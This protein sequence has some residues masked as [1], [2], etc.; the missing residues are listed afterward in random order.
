[1]YDTIII[2]AGPAG[3]TAGI[4]A[5]RKE[6]KTLIISKQVGGQ[7]AWAS[8]IENYPGFK[9]IDNYDLISRMQEQVK[10]LGVEIKIDEIQKIKKTKTGN[11]I[12]HTNKEKYKTKTI[13]ITIGMSPRRLAIPGEVKFTGH[14]VSYCANCDG[15]LY[16]N[17]I[18]AVVGGGNAAL[19]AA[20][21]LSKI[22]KKVYLIHRSKEF[23]AFSNLIKI[24]N[25]I[26]NIKFILN[27]EIKEITGENKIEKIKILNNK[28]NKTSELT[29][30]G[31]FVEIGRITN[32]DLVAGFVNRDKQDQIIVNEQCQTN[33]DGIFAAGDVTQVKFKQITIACGQATIA[34]LSAYQYL[35]LKSG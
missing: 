11:F 25:K 10:D 29:I 1:M 20:D 5:S 35:Q 31:L 28:N 18:V 19:D 12:V 8:T 9:S 6:M 23:R 22:A 2:G 4:Y 33:I 24:V 27:S 16:R 26:K 34:A 30:N 7:I 21:V 14:G 3:M 17:K 32:T 15:P 13:I